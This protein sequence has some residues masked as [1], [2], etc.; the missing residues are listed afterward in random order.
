[1]TKLQ[2]LAHS[3]SVMRGDPLFPPVLT[4]ETTLD[5]LDLDSLDVVELQ[6]MY[7]EDHGVEIPDSYDPII[8]VGDL[9]KILA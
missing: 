9:L 5:E 2:W 1:M 4:E 3:V 6:M 8:T 7:E